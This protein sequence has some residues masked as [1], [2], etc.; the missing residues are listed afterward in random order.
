MCP[1]SRAFVCLGSLGGAAAA[2][3]WE[4]P[5]SLQPRRCVAWAG[6]CSTSLERVALHRVQARE[7]PTPAARADPPGKVHHVSDVG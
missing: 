3:G 7:H 4:A 1:V 6:L 2:G 5:R